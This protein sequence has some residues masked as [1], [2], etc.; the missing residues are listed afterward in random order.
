MSF[1][2]VTGCSAGDWRGGPIGPRTAF[3]V[4]VEWRTP[5]SC[6]LDPVSASDRSQSQAIT[7]LA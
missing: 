3:S 5:Y 4:S 2:A 6:Q 1:S 7:G